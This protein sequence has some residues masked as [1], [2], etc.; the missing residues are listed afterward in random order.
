MTREEAKNIIVNKQL[1]RLSDQQKIK[2]LESYW[3]HGEDEMIKGWVSMKAIFL[4]SVNI[5][6]L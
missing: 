3:W 2:I 5:L 1:E 4:N 6:S